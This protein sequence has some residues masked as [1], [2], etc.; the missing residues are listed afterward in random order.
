MRSAVWI[1]DIWDPSAVRGY[2]GNTQATNE[3]R[4]A[5]VVVDCAPPNN[6]YHYL[7]VYIGWIWYSMTESTDPCCDYKAGPAG[8]DASAEIMMCT[9][10]FLRPMDSSHVVMNPNATCRCDLPVTTQPTT[11]GSV[12][13]LYR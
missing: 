9:D 10:Y 12:K 8:L 1:A 2:Y 11:W 6:Q 4:G 13:A 3:N 5:D 7:P